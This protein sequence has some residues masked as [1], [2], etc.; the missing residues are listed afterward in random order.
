MILVLIIISGCF[1]SAA[2]HST[3]PFRVWSISSVTYL[4]SGPGRVGKEGGSEVYDQ[5]R[6]P[7]NLLF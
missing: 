6:R 1:L 7:R 3:S 2:N 4:S 5:C